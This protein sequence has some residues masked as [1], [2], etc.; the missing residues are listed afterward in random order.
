M[1]HSAQDF[2]ES[3]TKRIGLLLLCAIFDTI[4]TTVKIEK[5]YL[6]VSTVMNGKEKKLKVL[7]GQTKDSLQL[8]EY[9]LQKNEWL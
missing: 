7:Y 5:D 2:R 1:K 6:S 4:G 8:L 3:I 9:L